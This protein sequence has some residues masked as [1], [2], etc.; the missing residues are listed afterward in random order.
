VI[1]ISPVLIKHSKQTTKRT[2]SK[3]FKQKKHRKMWLFR[4]SLR[5]NSR[6]C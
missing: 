4:V 6:K 3:S 1:E 2:S 5:L